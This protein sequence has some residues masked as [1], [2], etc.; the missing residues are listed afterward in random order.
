MAQPGRTGAVATID[1]AVPDP[2]NRAKVTEPA[3]FPYGYFQP[4]G[5]RLSATHKAL[6]DKWPREI[7][8]YEAWCAYTLYDS[9]A[10]YGGKRFNKKMQFLLANC[11]QSSAAFF[12]TSTHGGRKKVTVMEYDGDY[13]K[14]WLAWRDKRTQDLF[15]SD[16]A[17]GGATTMLMVAP[18][19]KQNNVSYHEQGYVANDYTARLVEERTGGPLGADYPK[20]AY[21]PLHNMPEDHLLGAFPTWIKVVGTKMECVNAM[22]L[23]I[24]VGRDK[25]CQG[26]NKENNIRTFFTG[27]KL[28]SAGKSDSEHTNGCV[29]FASKMAAFYGLYFYEG[30]N[31]KE[32]N[33]SRQVKYAADDAS[34]EY[35]VRM[36]Y[37]NPTFSVETHW[38]RAS[39]G[40]M[41]VV[42]RLAV[43]KHYEFAGETD[44][45]VGNGGFVVPEVAFFEEF[46]TPLLHEDNYLQQ[47]GA[48][49]TVVARMK[50]IVAPMYG[51]CVEREQVDALIP[52]FNTATSKPIN[53]SSN[54]SFFCG[55][56]VPAALFLYP[57]TNDNCTV[58]DVVE[59]LLHK[60]LHEMWQPAPKMAAN[61][62]PPTDWTNYD[63]ESHGNTPWAQSAR[64]A[65]WLQPFVVPSVT[66]RQKA[67]LGFEAQRVTTLQQYIDGFKGSDQLVQTRVPAQAPAAAVG[68]SGTTA[69]QRADIPIAG[70]ILRSR[71]GKEPA[72]PPPQQDTD[73]D[74]DD[75]DDGGGN[76][77][78]AVAPAST[79]ASE[80]YQYA[81]DTQAENND[82][83]PAGEADVQTGDAAEEGES[84]VRHRAT[85]LGTKLCDTLDGAVKSGEFALSMI[86]QTDE[87]GN[88]KHG[89]LASAA[90]NQDALH[91]LERDTRGN[92]AS[93]KPG[94]EHRAG[95]SFNSHFYNDTF[96]PWPAND[97]YDAPLAKWDYSD[98][99]K[100]R[101]KEY[102]KLYGSTANCYLRSGRIAR[103]ITG[104][105]VSFGQVKK[106][107]DQSILDTNLTAYKASDPHYHL[108][109]AA[110]RAM[111]RENMKRILCIYY[112]KSPLSSKV[113]FNDK[114]KGMINGIYVNAGGSSGKRGRK[115]TQIPAQ[116]PN[117]DRAGQQVLPAV[118]DNS[119]QELNS[120]RA[121]YNDT[122][123]GK[124]RAGGTVRPPEITDDADWVR[125]KMKLI[126][127][128]QTP[129]HYQYLPYQP[130]QSNFRDGETYCEGCRRCSR[131]FYEYKHRYE[132][133]HHTIKSTAHWP[134]RYWKPDSDSPNVAPVPFHDEKFW[135]ENVVVRAHVPSRAEAGS[136]LPR[137]PGTDS[138]TGY[139]NWSTHK[140]K[141]ATP[142]GACSKDLNTILKASLGAPAN[143][144]REVAV[145][146][147][148]LRVP[149]TYRKTVNHAY[150][151]ERK[152]EVQR[153]LVQGRLTTAA[154]KVRF[155]MTDYKLM[156]AVK[157]TNLCRDCAAVLDRAPGLLQKN[158]RPRPPAGFGDPVARKNKERTDNYG[159]D[160]R[161]E[162]QVTWQRE[163]IQGDVP[164]GVLTPFTEAFDP[165]VTMI[166]TNHN[167]DHNQ[168]IQRRQRHT[169]AGR[170][171][172]W[173][174]DRERV[175]FENSERRFTAHMQAVQRHL[176][177]TRCKFLK[178][179]TTFVVD[180][181]SVTEQA[182]WK[183]E[184]H[185]RR[186][187]YGKQQVM[188]AVQ[189]LNNE[190]VAKATKFMDELKRQLLE[191]I[192]N[193][194]E[195]DIVI[196]ASAF[197]VG[198]SHVYFLVHDAQHHV[199]RRHQYKVD[200]NAEAKKFDPN[201]ARIELRNQ[202]LDGHKNC[203][204]IEGWEPK[205]ARRTDA[206]NYALDDT[207]RSWKFLA[208]IGANDDPNQDDNP[209][210]WQGDGAIQRANVD[211]AG[212]YSEVI[213]QRQIR[214]MKQSRFFITYSLHRP[215]TSEMEARLIME[216]MGNA[217]RTLFGSDE[218]L[219]EMLVFGMKLAPIEPGPEGQRADTVSTRKYVP[220][221]SGRKSD[222][223]FYGDKN[224]QT[225]SYLYDTYE[226]HVDSVYV[227]V[228]VEIGP[229]LHH[230]HFHA[231]LTINHFSYLQLDYYKMQH[232]LECMFKGL[233]CKQFDYSSDAAKKLY[234]LQDAGGF[235]FYTDNEN[236][237]IDFRLYPTD[238]WQEV[239]ASYVRKSAFAQTATGLETRTSGV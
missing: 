60:G 214:N 35:T 181:V 189:S 216:R 62:S 234:F 193:G 8:S 222:T 117:F 6:K 52:Q 42:V 24:T 174:N 230:P 212:N 124:L 161:A 122:R 233:K 164:T 146:S 32:N 102:E 148:R 21:R 177:S 224:K 115:G 210:Q 204:V 191:N 152:R 1:T 136:A 80:P 165:S 23:D 130:Q 68:G 218:H 22:G 7:V 11:Y 91:K 163:G 128:L 213:P 231:L 98:M 201:M 88:E 192:E 44:K 4:K 53:P 168:F 71:K 126:D 206:G 155:G 12:P 215:V 171:N 178:D 9:N 197:D 125:S 73:D 31:K 49:E 147:L 64:L 14:K 194:Q 121:A 66:E 109:N 55:W 59:G 183:P 229:T 54:E 84:G 82:E 141:P 154:A 223:V 101:L 83:D 85:A 237:Y 100:Q 114:T 134:L 225:N 149:F 156:R 113:K 29:A 182:R 179:D 72:Q 108:L 129:W 175:E 50:T 203:L 58:G 211:S 166:T 79:A 38:N 135:D 17:V 87:D 120:H 228:G 170:P 195:A 41:K 26:V 103:E 184:V 57:H 89:I 65:R 34:A 19:K 69:A 137:A 96:S 36:R 37:P 40:A 119:E 239:I 207:Y 106:I 75:D 93:L 133:Y 104:V 110:Q 169:P 111:F 208:T 47:V 198:N 5:T 162:L 20:R 188:E 107:G 94:S 2:T 63:T 56:R 227:D 15:R 145:D 13:A 190:D 173:R 86:N 92:K 159:L 90:L 123:D 220:I 153:S 39:A 209:G 45:T 232:I 99:Q 172:E 139:H 105:Q 48:G 25:A 74:D 46:D 187:G 132:A 3:L 78:P 157:F 28:Q 138:D 236:P 116:D 151:E 199:T 140:F 127:W 238:N 235:P 70:R 77:A 118:F 51:Q 131:P 33:W 221:L 226:T 202:Q 144:A 200:T 10:E 196:P 186:T 43:N 76:D 185:K 167:D 217:V 67:A 61:A 219:C 158:E 150:D 143:T 142:N 30:C 205:N 81:E 176:E 18:K 112:D 27:Q 97:V 180:R 95:E 160:S 16:L